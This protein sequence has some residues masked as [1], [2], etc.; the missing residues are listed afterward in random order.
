MTD[1]VPEGDIEFMNVVERVHMVNQ[2]PD[3][4]SAEYDSTRDKTT[5]PGFE[6]AAKAVGVP[7]NSVRMTPYGK[8]IKAR[9]QSRQAFVR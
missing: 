2:L 7:L 5:P 8:I 1:V 9:S 3:R 4:K 6:D